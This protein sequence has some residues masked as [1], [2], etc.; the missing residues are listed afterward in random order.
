MSKAR[1]RSNRDPNWPMTTE[2][3]QNSDRCGGGGGSGMRGKKKEKR[4]M[5]EKKSGREKDHRE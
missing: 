3:E 2:K 4:Q 5:T 1:Q